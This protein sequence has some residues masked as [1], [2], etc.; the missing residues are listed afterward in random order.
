MRKL[1]CLLL[2]GMALI[3][4]TSCGGGY[5]E[6]QQ[7]D[8]IEAYEGWIATANEHDPN[9]FTATIRLE[10]LRLAAAREA[11][12]LEAFDAYL[13]ARKILSQK[14]IPAGWSPSSPQPFAWQHHFDTFT[15]GRSKLPKPKPSQPQSPL[16]K[17]VLD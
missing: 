16:S 6:V 4:F 7:A 2:A 12:T 3:G 11:G 14:G 13:E 8:T 1:A 9:F 15:N 10:E 17:A 5:H